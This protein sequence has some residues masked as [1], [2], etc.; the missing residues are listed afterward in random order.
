MAAATTVLQ[1]APAHQ[2]PVEPHSLV[3]VRGVVVLRGFGIRVTVDRGH[4]ILE[5]GIGA[6]RQSLRL[7]RVGHGL[8]RLVV[9]GPD[10]LVTL[11]ALRWLADQ[12][13]AFVMLDR[14]GRILANTAPAGSNDGR[15][16]RAQATVLHTGLALP[17]VADLLDRKLASQEHLI[18]QAFAGSPVVEDIV[19]ARLA[20]KSAQTIPAMR[21]LEAHAALAYW[22]AWHDVAVTFPSN[23]LKSVPDHWRTFGAR[24][25]PLTGSGR[26]AVNPANAMLNYLY[27]VL[28]SEA[29]IAATAV[30]LDP[31]V[32][33]LHVETN[34]RD[35]LAC[36][37][38]EVV[39]AKV[40]VYVLDWLRREPLKRGWFFEERD[41][42]CRL[43]APLAVRLAQTAPMWDRL[44][45]PIA[46][47]VASAL[48]ATVPRK[49]HRNRLPTLPTETHQRAV[50]GHATEPAPRSLRPPRLC[51]TCGILLRKG[52][53][54]CATCLREEL[55]E[56]F[57]G[58]M[59]RGRSAAQ[60]KRAQTRRAQTQRAHER[61]RRD[62][63]PDRQPA[64]LT[65]SFYRDEIERRL[66]GV[67][68]ASIASVLGV[69]ESYAAEIRR[70]LR[71]PHP[72]HWLQLARLVGAS[73]SSAS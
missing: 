17:I 64:W 38:M 46:E 1:P 66:S 2:R 67:P 11:A 22:S 42:G 62:W 45:A 69:S 31:R 37:L 24:R 19:S 34:A 39:R 18:R 30:G 33:L 49:G 56:T 41:G 28:E 63:S 12:D 25:S 15:L 60:S 16:R 13:S 47:H 53:A 70:G 35:S 65:Q 61:A 26:R 14:A 7:P 3:P 6:D 73:G 72:R 21:V 51:R 36:D 20:L 58:V 23:D 8:R 4:L 68:S 50:H 59:E 55:R 52:R 29:R 32:G 43:M 9:I 5:D 27:A 40:D 54:R 57:P 48:W 10:G 44:V 71:S